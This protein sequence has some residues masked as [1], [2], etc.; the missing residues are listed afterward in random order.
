[1]KLE[2]AVWFTGGLTPSNQNISLYLSIIFID[3]KPAVDG[4]LV[5]GFVSQIIHNDLK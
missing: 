4:K 1:V 3:G 5:H 2:E